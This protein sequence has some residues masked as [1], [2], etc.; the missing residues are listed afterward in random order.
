MPAGVQFDADGSGVVIFLVAVYDRTPFHQ[1]SQK[2]AD[3]I[4]GVCAQ[5][6]GMLGTGGIEIA[7]GNHRGDNPQTESAVNQGVEY[8][9]SVELEIAGVPLVAPD[10]VNFGIPCGAAMNADQQRQGVAVN[11]KR[12]ITETE[13]D[14]VVSV[15][16]RQGRAP[17]GC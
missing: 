6:S 16:S 15:A 10:D 14:I 2:G 11:L 7:V 17:D 5:C 9:L 3:V 1:K 13:V 12:F 4:F 8:Y